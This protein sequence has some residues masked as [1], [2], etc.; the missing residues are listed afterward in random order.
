MQLHNLDDVIFNKVLGIVMIMVMAMIIIRPEKKLLHMEEIEELTGKRKIY[1]IIAFF[2]V[3]IYGGFIQAG[4]GFIMIVSLTL[5][6]GMLLQTKLTLSRSSLV[7]LTEK[8]ILK[9]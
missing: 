4:V 2:F 8:K 1:A 7:L 9:Y 6:T 3:G 5:I